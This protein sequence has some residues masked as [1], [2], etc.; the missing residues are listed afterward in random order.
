MCCVW[1]PNPVGV[2]RPCV[3]KAVVGD[4]TPITPSWGPGIDRREVNRGRTPHPFIPGH[5][6]RLAYPRA[7]PESRAKMSD[8]LLR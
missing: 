3:T 2:D 1:G 7:Y 4:N 6:R 5:N 8:P